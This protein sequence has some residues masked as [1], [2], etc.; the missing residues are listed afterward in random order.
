MR[1][2]V[3]MSMLVEGAS[4]DIVGCEVGEPFHFVSEHLANE[5][6]AWRG[7]CV[8]TPLSAHQS[9]KSVAKVNPSTSFLL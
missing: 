3:V 8:S 4:T 2:R 5:H 9:R 7:F 6:E 1:G